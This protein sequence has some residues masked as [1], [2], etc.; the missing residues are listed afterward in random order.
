MSECSEYEVS[1]CS[2]GIPTHDYRSEVTIKRQKENGYDPFTHYGTRDERAK[3]FFV[4]FKYATGEYKKWIEDG[5][6]H[7][8]ENLDQIPEDVEEVIHAK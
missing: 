5:G 8:K 1:Y 6:C 7:D 3:R 2:Y 4:Y